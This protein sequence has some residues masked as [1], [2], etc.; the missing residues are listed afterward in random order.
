[1]DFLDSSRLNMLEEVFVGS[2]QLISDVKL[3]KETKREIKRIIRNE[4]S[5]FLI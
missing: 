3:I 5:D 2:V 1:V 4:R